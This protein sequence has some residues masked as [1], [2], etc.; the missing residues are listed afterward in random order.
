MVSGPERRQELLAHSLGGRPGTGRTGGDETG[1]GRGGRVMEHLRIDVGLELETAFHTTG[2]LRRLG[3]DKALARSAEGHW[4]I[5]A[6]T[7]KGFLRENAEIL[8]RT[9]GHENVCTG[10]EPATMCKDQ[11]LCLV[12]QIFGNPRHPSPLRFSDAVLLTFEAETAVRSGVA[13]SRHRRAAFPQRLFFLE[14][15][16]AIPTR[17][18]ATCEGEFKDLHIAKAAAALVALA[19]RWGRAV[20]GGKTRGLGWIKDVELKTTLN[21]NTLLEDDLFPFWQAWKEGKDVAEG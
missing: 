5:P 4:V 6:T 12:C 10:P 18:H 19:A 15:T 20:G 1:R 8:L 11:P 9:W 13:I 17:W 16:Q 21:G 7:L 3:A 2:N 14:T